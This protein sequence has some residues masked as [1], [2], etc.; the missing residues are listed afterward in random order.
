M[1][2]KDILEERG[3]KGKKF[4]LTLFGYKIAD[5]LKEN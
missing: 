2:K 5:K 1:K 3:Y 4:Q